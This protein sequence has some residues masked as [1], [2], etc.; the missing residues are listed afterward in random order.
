MAWK[1]L[2]EFV[3]A[4][5]K[6][7]DLK[8]IK[9]F[10]DPE[11]E[12]TE[13]A[14]RFVKNNGPALLFEN[15]G[16]AFPL[17]INAFASGKRLAMAC[18][19][20]DIG[21]LI[22]RI[23]RIPASMPSAP[24]SFLSKIKGIPGLLNLVNLIPSR[25]SR[26]GLCQH[27]IIRK[28]D[29]SIM[30]VLKCWP[31][32][33]GRYITLPV[34]NTYHP[35]TLKPNAGMY[36]MQVLG[37]DTTAMHWQLHKTGANHFEAWKK[38]GRKMPVSV[39]LGGDP[40][41]TYAATAP[42]PENIDEYLL[43]GFIRGR[44][45]KLVKCITND[46]YVPDD[47]DF[48]IEGFVDPLEEPVTEGPFGDHTGFYSLEGPY[49]R[50][51]VTCIT[52]SR[53]PVYPATIV[54]VP[55]MEDYQ[56]T[57]LTSEI[58]Q[59]PLKLTLLPELEDMHLPAP[60]VAHNLAIVKIQKRWPGQGKKVINSVFGAGQMMF[61]KFLVVVSEDTDIRDY[62]SLARVVFSSC[63]PSHDLVFTRGPLD[64]LDHASDTEAYGGKLGIDA[65]RKVP[66]EKTD[67]KQDIPLLTWSADPGTLLTAGLITAYRDLRGE[68][69]IPVLIA[70]VKN[71]GGKT[72]IAAIKD[73]LK[74]T[75]RHS[76]FG[77]FVA[78]DDGFDLSD[79]SL[80][81]WYILGNTDPVRDI[82]NIEGKLYFIDATTKAYRPGGF[83][84]PWP[85]IVCSDDDTIRRIDEKWEDLGPAPFIK[86]PS[87]RFSKAFR[88]GSAAIK[89]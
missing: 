74:E 72:N 70:A 39:I 23:S 64:V 49:P 45:V 4:L 84:R 51:H 5:E 32:D 65:T 37:P 68:F 21:H 46:I 59:A 57:E 79:I 78:V 73:F 83:P 20:E 50:F 34:V 55:P 71:T 8:R 56:F 47:A 28:P 17:L 24:S 61:T 30:P 88:P 40:V 2:N 53:N 69:D 26:R 63:N 11:L 58:F 7:G 31:H 29:L 75:A 80:C 6:R 44:K 25:S 89:A 27:T 33:G 85:G 76:G 12:I 48:V 16:T 67:E 87:L 41:Y 13:I 35:E 14:D 3:S 18:S 86:S 42:L 36:R 38:T 1:G 15:N 52:H 82:E 81:T 9:T 19:M 66:Q 22:S 60:G 62:K 54:G 77:L 43:A 10:F